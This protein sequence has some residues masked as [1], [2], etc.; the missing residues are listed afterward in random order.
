MVGGGYCGHTNPSHC[1]WVLNG[2]DPTSGTDRAEVAQ[3]SNGTQPDRN[4]RGHS[5]DFGKHDSSNGVIEYK[6]DVLPALKGKLVVARFSGGDD[7]IVLTL[8]ST[9]KDV[10]ASK[11]SYVLRPKP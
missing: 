7:L 6:S 10:S 8:S 11:T 4:W 3:Y 5:F 1:E 2:G 9:T